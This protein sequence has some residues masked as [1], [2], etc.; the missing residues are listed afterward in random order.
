M[1]RLAEV[2]E[3]VV[4]PE[5]P[6]YTRAED[7]ERL[8]A[9]FRREFGFSIVDQ[10]SHTTEHAFMWLRLKIEDMGISVYVEPLGH[11][12]FRGLSVFFN[13]FPAIVIDQHEKHVGA[14]IFTLFHE[15]A[16]LLIRQTGISDHGWSSDLE[17]FG[18]KF[19]AA[20][21]MPPKAIRA[22]FEVPEKGL[23]DPSIDE[24]S[25]G[26]RKLCVTI[27]QLALRLETLGFARGGRL[28][29]TISKQTKTRTSQAS[30]V[31]G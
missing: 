12:D 28:L 20:F 11:D 2:D 13:D 19:A 10:L 7:P 16:H 14:R 15:Y 6:I 21:L 26:A 27:S 9:T 25:A 4:A 23:I 3:Q 29:G 22:V 17:T 24:L 30:A 31:R 1:A 5:L 18:N 8:G